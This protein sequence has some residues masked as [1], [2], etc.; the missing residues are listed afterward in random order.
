MDAVRIDKF[1]WAA[2]F[3]KTRS[4]AQAVLEAGRVRVDGQRVKP[5]RGVR[6]GS[7]ITFPQGRM[8]RHIKVLEISDQR[9]GAPDAAR[10][11]DDLAPPSPEPL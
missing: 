4:L 3:F 11:Y 7:E 5:S 9:K 1:L 8:R 2:R 10:L 6:V